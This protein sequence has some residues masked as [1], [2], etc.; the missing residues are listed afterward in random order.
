[1]NCSSPYFNLTFIQ[2]KKKF[3]WWVPY[4]LID[5]QKQIYLKIVQEHLKRFKKGENFL[6]R[7]V[8]IEEIWIQDFVPES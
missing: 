2:E 6:N 3:G 8:A 4:A 1:M 5:T 7:I